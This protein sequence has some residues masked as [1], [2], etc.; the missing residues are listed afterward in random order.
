MCGC[1]SCLEIYPVSEIECW[2]DDGNTPL[3]P[4]CLVD[5]VLIGETNVDALKKLYGENFGE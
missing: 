2:V 5:A 3:C 4:Y 1:Y